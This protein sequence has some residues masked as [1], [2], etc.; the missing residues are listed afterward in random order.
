MRMIQSKYLFSASD[1]PVGLH[2]RPECAIL[3]LRNWPSLIPGCLKTFSYKITVLAVPAARIP[4]TRHPS[5]CRGHSE[6]LSW[7]C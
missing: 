6:I 2:W 7:A 1:L 5:R 4:H 3:I